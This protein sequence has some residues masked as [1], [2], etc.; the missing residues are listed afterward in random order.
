MRKYHEQ[1][2]NRPQISRLM[3]CRPVADIAGGEKVT[4]IKF[5]KPGATVSRLPTAESTIPA[6]GSMT[7][8]A[9]VTDT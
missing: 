7:P 4:F 2:G 1:N 3:A 9:A 8:P 5:L 6:R